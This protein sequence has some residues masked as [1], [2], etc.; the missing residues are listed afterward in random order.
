MALLGK[1]TL[2]PSDKKQFTID[3]SDW[4]DTGETVSSMAYTVAWV[5]GGNGSSTLITVSGGSIAGDGKS[6][7]F[8]VNGNSDLVSTLA[9]VTA[10]MTSSST[11]SLANTMEFLVVSP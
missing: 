6:V 3:Y 10:T 8:F 5:S 2:A 7:S 11:E 4:L 9:K 1:R